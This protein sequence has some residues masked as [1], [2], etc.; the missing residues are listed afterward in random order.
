MISTI[1]VAIDDTPAALAGARLAVDLAGPLH[2]TVHAVAVVPAE[3]AVPR[4]DA[5]RAARSVLSYVEGLAKAAGVTVETVVRHG[6]AAPCIL[7]EARAIGADV[8]VLGR[9]GRTGPG[10]PYIGSQTREVLEFAE[11]PVIV[12]PQTVRHHH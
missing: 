6:D 2:A 9:S 11:V 5:A 10:Q 12:V 3:M 8:V 1:I 7:A 4:P